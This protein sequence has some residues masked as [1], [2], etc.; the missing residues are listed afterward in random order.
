MV[1]C[2]GLRLNVNRKNTISFE[3]A[4]TMIIRDSGFLANT[5]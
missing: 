1:L 3:V 5:I 2:I 4:T